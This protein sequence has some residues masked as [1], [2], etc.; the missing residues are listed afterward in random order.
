MNIALDITIVLLGDNGSLLLLLGDNGSL[1]FW[2]WRS[3]YNFQRLQTTV[4]PGSMDSEAGIF[5]IK[6]DKSG[7]R[8]LTCEADKTIKIYK[9]DDTAVSGYETT[10]SQVFETTL[11]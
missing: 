5:A 6:F 1:L 10:L 2:D 4:Q 3:G 11:P 9:E 7:T 8:M